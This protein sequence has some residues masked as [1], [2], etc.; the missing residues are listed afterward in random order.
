[1]V[2]RV[3]ASFGEGK[4]VKSRRQKALSGGYM[5]GCIKYAS[6]FQG[7]EAAQS[8]CPR[9]STKA[10]GGRAERQNTA[11]CLLVFGDKVRFKLAEG[12]IV[13]CLADIFHCP[14]QEADIVHGK[15]PVA[16]QFS[17]AEQMA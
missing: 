12:A 17:A 14:G 13:Y 4:Q 2:V 7:A 11:T 1:M 15:Q 9:Q 5:L 10:V 3:A 16:G 8:Y 6:H